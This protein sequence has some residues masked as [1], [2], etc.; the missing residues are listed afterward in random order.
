M[1]RSFI[2]LL[3][4]AIEIALKKILDLP[5]RNGGTAGILKKNATLTRTEVLVAI[6]E[7]L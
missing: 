4:S 6:N 1:K 3:R 7:T 2:A 5:L